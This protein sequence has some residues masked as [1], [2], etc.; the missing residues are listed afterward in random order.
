MGRSIVKNHKPEGF[1]ITLYQ[2]FQMSLHFL[3]SLT[4]M[5]GIQA[6]T[7]GI[8]QT[9]KQSTPGILYPRSIYLSLLPFGNIAVTHI[10]Q[11]TQVSG[12]KEHQ[13][14]LLWGNTPV[15]IGGIMATQRSF[16]GF[17]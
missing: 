8:Y 1:W 5:N 3:V 10:W 13:I 12:V 16:P 17:F 14:A 4:L 11:P 7:C 9:P 6:F 2:Q 15:C